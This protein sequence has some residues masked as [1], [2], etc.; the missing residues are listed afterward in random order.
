MNQALV[1]AVLSVAVL[2]IPYAAKAQVGH[3]SR[4]SGGD[5]RP[6]ECVS[7]HVEYVEPSPYV[8]VDNPSCQNVVPN[9]V[10]LVIHAA[11]AYITNG[12]SLQSPEVLDAYINKYRTRIIQGM[13][14]A[15]VAGTIGEI[16]NGV[17]GANYASCR[18]MTVVLPAGA[19]VTRILLGNH[20]DAAGGAECPPGGG[21]CPQGWS[22]YEAPVTD[23]PVVWTIAKNWSHNRR[24]TANFRVYWRR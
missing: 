4:C 24:N 13:G 21:K 20:N 12:E 22:G 1:G 19:K 8:Q 3:A 14:A 17:V 23:G 2:A 10:R 6:G 5:L 18:V 16:L 15:H 11:A 7:S 9:E